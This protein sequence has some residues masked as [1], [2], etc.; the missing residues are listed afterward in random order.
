[1]ALEASPQEVLYTPSAPALSGA[2]LRA[3]LE[4]L[5]ELSAAQL[6]TILAYAAQD[7]PLVAIIRPWGLLGD[8]WLTFQTVELATGLHYEHKLEPDGR[9]WHLGQAQPANS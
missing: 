2:A 1:M 8:G 6:Q 4:D 7:G 5:G 9:A 3:E